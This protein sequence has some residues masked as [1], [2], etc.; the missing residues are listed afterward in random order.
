MF[1]YIISVSLLWPLLLETSLH[2][3]L[4]ISEIQSIIYL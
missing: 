2:K 3:S 1:E 4:E